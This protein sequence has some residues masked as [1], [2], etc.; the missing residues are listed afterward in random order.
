[1]HELLE[2]LRG[3]DASDIADEVV[4][5]PPLIGVL[6]DGMLGEE[7]D[8]QALAATAA[9]QA[10]R[11]RPELLAP[12]ADGLID[13]AGCARDAATRRCLAQMLARVELSDERAAQATEILDAYLAD[14]DELVQAWALS[15]IVALANEH[16]ALRAH[17]GAVVRERIESDAPPVGERARLLQD[18]AESWPS[19]SA[20]AS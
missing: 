4:A 20:G 8:I 6:L 14:A 7:G 2:R 13:A 16:P 15:A 5:D 17:A 11:E 19:G 3:S 1:V 12:H 10:A 9:E 18:Q